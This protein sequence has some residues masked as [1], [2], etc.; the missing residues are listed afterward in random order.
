MHVLMLVDL[1]L[2]HKKHV[3]VFIRE[4]K[5][6]GKSFLIQTAIYFEFNAWHTLFIEFITK[7]II[8]RWYLFLKCYCYGDHDLCHDGES[9]F[10]YPSSRFFVLIRLYMWR[11]NCRNSKNFVFLSIRKII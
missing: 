5:S 6:M 4:I 10:L 9:H 1:T 3:M 7:T 2:G 8:G 11:S